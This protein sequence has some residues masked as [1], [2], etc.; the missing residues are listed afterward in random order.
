[1]ESTR[2]ERGGKI[3]ETDT[4]KAIALLAFLVVTGQNHPRDS[5]AAFFWPELD[6][7]H[8]RGALRRTLSSLKSAIGSDTIESNRDLIGLASRVNLW[9]DVLEFRKLIQKFGTPGNYSLDKLPEI[10]EVL[11][12]A[13]ELYH[14]DFMAGFSLRDSLAFDDWQ[15]FQSEA[16]RSDL[17]SALER[18]VDGH[19]LL[20]NYQ[21]AINYARRWLSLDALQ[22]SAHRALMSLYAYSGRRE[23]ALR[24]YQ[25]CER[26]LE[27][28]LG[29]PPLEETVQLYLQIKENRLQI[30]PMRV[31]AP[32]TPVINQRDVS[33]KPL[34]F[35]G[36][37]IEFERL[38]SAYHSIQSD[39]RFI[40]I[41]G[42]AG[43]G[44]TRLADEFVANAL[45][46]GAIIISARAYQGEHTLSYGPIIEGLRAAMSLPTRSNWLDDLPEEILS[47]VSRLLPE[48]SQQRRLTRSLPPL[49]DAGAQS[50]FFEAIHRF[51]LELSRGPVPGIL[52][53]DDLQWA[54]TATTDLLIYLV[55]RSS[56]RP[57]LV[58]GAW[59]GEEVPF[60]HRLRL[61]MGE[62]QRNRR[63]VLIS[64]ARLNKSEV[65]QLVGSIKNLEAIDT[66]SDRLYQE[67][68]GLP[69][70]LS[71]YLATVENQAD[72][73]PNGD[74]PIPGS[75]QE[76]LRYRLSKISEMGMQ[77]LSAAAIIGR[78][79]GFDTL[80]EVSGRGEE[81]TVQSLE[82]LLSQ[83]LIKEIKDPGEDNE[84]IYDFNHEKLREIVNEQISAARRRLLHRRIANTL[85]SRSRSQGYPTANSSQIAFH[86]LHAGEALQAGKYFKFAGE[87][88]RSVY[89]N[90]DAIRHYKAALDLGNQ[91]SDYLYEAIGDI[92]TLLG[93]YSAGLNNYSMVRPDPDSPLQT[94]IEHKKGKV[95]HR[96]GEWALAEE[97]Y[98][99]ALASLASETPTRLSVHILVDWSLAAHNQ[100]NEN[101]AQ[102]LARKALEAAEQVE[103]T[104]AL[105]QV[106]NILGILA[107]KQGNF[108]VA[109]SHLEYSLELA[110]QLGDPCTCAA[111]LN[112]MALLFS[113]SGELERAIQLTESALQLCSRVGDRHREA[114]LESNLA[115]LLH[116]AGKRESAIEHL[117]NSVTIMAEIGTETGDFRPEIWKLTEW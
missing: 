99:L 51:V 42:E 5:L 82:E 78:S 113:E 74:W 14:T 18:L 84:P 36:R 21:V 67:T 96:L 81:E 75:V 41:E 85:V 90:R 22:E 61:L 54:D 24:Q 110:D 6:H 26:I 64:L 77:L 80:R 76:L 1:L 115:D 63:G 117:K 73:P 23:T 91:D 87:Y 56:G 44:K 38:L 48:L 83:G 98:R 114:A 43:I 79:F 55:R 53:I 88:A 46:A 112:N 49:E 104:L 31:H 92:N 52:F 100:N 57:L 10:L 8:A 29:V 62:V 108:P 32:I 17:A 95:Y 109:Q 70:F 9:S 94:V 97:H 34:P 105:S 11:H 58:L 12:L 106:H 86:Y 65:T 69:Y 16:L 30:P 25:E 2:L 40:V 59:R 4:R 66:L 101:E 93:E 116:R 68:E 50:R 33:L 28:E 15:F 111:T 71:E 103:D 7:S 3:V 39:A 45:G 89:A 107:R 27:K 47:E 35:V 19:I 102:D 37:S 60:S 20:G 13:I 72:S